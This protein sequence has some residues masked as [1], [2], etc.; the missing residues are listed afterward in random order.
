M[1]VSLTLLRDQGM[2]FLRAEMRQVYAG[3][4]IGRF[5]P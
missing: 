3:Q 1:Q 2:A 5:H 4:G